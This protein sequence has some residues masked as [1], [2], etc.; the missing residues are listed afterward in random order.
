MLYVL[1]PVPVDQHF[2]LYEALNWVAYRQYA[3]SWHFIHGEGIGENLVDG[4]F[5]TNRVSYPFIEKE[6]YKKN[7]LKGHGL[8]LPKEPKS[9]FDESFDFESISKNESQKIW[10]KERADYDQYQRELSEIENYCLAP[11]KSELFLKLRSG[12]ISAYG[13][14]HSKFKSGVSV[15][16]WSD[17][18]SWELVLFESDRVYMNDLEDI[19]N[20]VPINGFQKISQNFWDSEGVVWDENFARSR[21]GW[22]HWI[23]VK[24]EEV[25][26]N[27]PHPTGKPIAIEERAGFFVYDDNKIEGQHIISSKSKRG[28]P[29]FNWPQFH[30]EVARYILESGGLPKQTALERH[31][32]MWCNDNWGF[33]PSH[34]AIH[35]QISPHYK[36]IEKVRKSKP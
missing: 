3:A 20:G 13:Q 12:E 10:D 19:C 23:F 15:S 22:F 6:D 27:F 28:R 30:A 18:E 34:G 14:V 9:I 31:M 35:E 17:D 29:P 25:F 24:S 33:T 7:L 32:E 21:H 1:E 26:L 2:T 5:E 11:A 4:L 16:K 8:E 36:T